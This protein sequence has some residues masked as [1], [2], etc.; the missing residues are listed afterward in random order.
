[1]V[2]DRFFVLSKIFYNIFLNGHEKLQNTT[3]ISNTTN[4]NHYDK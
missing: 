4:N 1:M 3:T 2:F